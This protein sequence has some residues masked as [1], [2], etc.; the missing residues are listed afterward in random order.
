MSLNVN[1]KVK[2][3]TATPTNLNEDERKMIYEAFDLIL[4]GAY[5]SDIIIFIRQYEKAHIRQSAKILVVGTI[6]K[7]ITKGKE[8]EK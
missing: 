2:A 8:R 1:G 5:E 3:E 7:R 4:D 6:S